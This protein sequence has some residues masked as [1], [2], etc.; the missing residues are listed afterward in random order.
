MAATASPEIVTGGDEG[1]AAA[2]VEARV[3]AGSSRVTDDGVGDGAGWDSGTDEEDSGACDWTCVA[4]DGGC[5]CDGAAGCCW[6]CW[7]C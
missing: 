2:E 1:E 5:S 7:P 3:G 4:W 6:P